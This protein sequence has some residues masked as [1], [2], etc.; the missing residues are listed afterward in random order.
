ME[1]GAKFV[2]PWTSGEGVSHIIVDSEMQ[3]EDVLKHVNMEELPDHITIVNQRYPSDCIS[4]Q[5]LVDPN[6]KLYD[7]VR[8]Q[9]RA[10]SA[11]MR[12]IPQEERTLVQQTPIGKTK[13]GDLQKAMFMKT[14]PRA[15]MKENRADDETIKE[16]PVR[17]T[18]AP[19]VQN[20]SKPPLRSEGRPERGM[21]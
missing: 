20:S 10:N 14:F 4:N 16:T 1:Y 7:V 18:A 3:Y 2:H 5:I 6:Q 21:P 13:E 11:K 15:T 17:R 12:Q 19:A 9:P 8:R